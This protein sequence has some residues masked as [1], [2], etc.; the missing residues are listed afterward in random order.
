MIPFLIGGLAGAAVL[1]SATVARFEREAAAELNSSLQGKG[2][3][4]SVQ[5]RVNLESLFGTV[6]SITIA[7]SHFVSEKLPFHTEPDRSKYAILRRLHLELNDFTLAGLKVDSLDAVVSGCRFDMGL[8]L[9]HHRFRLSQSGSGPVTVTI[10][11][12]SFEPFIL[13]KFHDVRSV[14]VR[15]DSNSVGI[16]GFVQFGFI[17]TQFQVQSQLAVRGGTRLVFVDPHV[18]LGSGVP[19]PRLAQLLLK[20]FDPI[21]D[22]DKDLHL[23]HAVTVTSLEMQNGFLVGHG[24]VIIPTVQPDNPPKT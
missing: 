16:S 11:D 12:R 2:R 6:P 9:S 15:M 7:A 17:A 19:D 22:L 14:S 20:I 13:A 10:R 1:G 3:K 4:V 5:A 23:E 8:A 21:L 18:S 24:T